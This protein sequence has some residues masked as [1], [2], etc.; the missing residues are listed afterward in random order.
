MQKHK[1]IVHKIICI[2]LAVCSAAALGIDFE[3]GAE[4]GRGGIA[5]L[6]SFHGWGMGQAVFVFFL[7]AFYHD[8]HKKTPHIQKDTAFFSL[9]LSV[10]VLIGLCYRNATGIALCMLN[11]V[12]LCKTAIVLIGYGVLFYGLLVLLLRFMKDLSV[13]HIGK[14][15]QEVGD[16]KKNAVRTAAFLFVC[17]LLI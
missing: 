14:K 3:S 10:L 11:T 15:T 7:A 5:V 1:E 12:Q 9:F 6:S 13:K 2:L 8:I 17:W 16:E 4:T